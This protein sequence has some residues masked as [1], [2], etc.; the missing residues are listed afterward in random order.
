MVIKFY[1]QSFSNFGIIIA[2]LV[3]LCGI[4]FNFEER[5]IKDDQSTRYYDNGCEVR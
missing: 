5:S 3:L 4:L 2:L 1:I